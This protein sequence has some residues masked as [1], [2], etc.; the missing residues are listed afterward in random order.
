MGL[1]VM[2]IRRIV[3]GD[4]RADLVPAMVARLLE[5]L[6]ISATEAAQLADAATTT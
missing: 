4:D 6:G 2:T 3:A 1:L 5:T